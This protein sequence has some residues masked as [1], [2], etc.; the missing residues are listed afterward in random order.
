M[1]EILACD[2]DNEDEDEDGKVGGAG[3]LMGRCARIYICH[4]DYS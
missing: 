2:E 3:G 4:R 1:V